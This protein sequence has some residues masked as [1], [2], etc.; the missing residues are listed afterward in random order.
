MDWEIIMSGARRKDKGQT[1]SSSDKEFRT[2]FE[3]DYDRIIFSTPFRRLADKTQVFP[4]EVND[5]V[6]TRLT[7]SLEVSNLARSIGT[8][9]AFNLKL[10]PEE[11]IPQRNIP[12]VLGAIGL[13]HDLGNPPFGHQGEVAI[14][15]WFEKKK[16][17][18]FNDKFGLTEAMT[19]DFLSFEGNAQTLRLLTRLQVVNDDFGLNLTYGTLAGLMKYPVPSNKVDDCTVGSKKFGFFQSE[20]S[21]V[22][23]IWKKTGLAEGVRHPLTYIMEA[24][25]DI[26]YSV[27]DAE[28]TVK[29]QLVSFVDLI[30]YLRHNGSEDPVVSEVI[31]KSMD[32][33]SS[34][35]SAI[36]SPVE[37]NDIAMQMFRVHSISLMTQK[38]IDIYKVKHDE[39]THGVQQ[40]LDLVSQSEAN[41]LC[42]ILKKFDLTYGY[43]HKSVL[44]LELH[45]YNIVNAL[46][47]MIWEAITSRKIHEDVSSKRDT[48][49]AAYVYSKISENYRRVFESESNK[50]PIRYR[51]CQLL[52]DMI[53]G[54]TE[55][56]SILFYE[57]IKRY[58]V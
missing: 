42:K 10:F 52:T 55:S 39:L 32:T 48:P 49:F 57:D 26:A 36:L 58:K 14:R 13:A 2:N 29:K 21:I 56:F 23:D 38:I 51:E 11:I 24:C 5:S 35:R 30:E 20:Q 25:D 34:F 40:Q 27:I 7:H 22:E 3:R 28:D 8:A 45:G 46:M 44:A 31:R 18:I 53:S 16:S 54:M 37:L 50:L 19:R 33:H 12:A 6:R 4:L 15:E 47:D 1:P 41:D 43:K 17:D 9:L